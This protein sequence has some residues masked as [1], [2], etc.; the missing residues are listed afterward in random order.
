MQNRSDFLNSIRLLV[1]R[2]EIEDSE[3]EKFLSLLTEARFET[4]QI[5][6]LSRLGTIVD[7]VKADIEREI[8][9][10]GDPDMINEMN[11][12]IEEIDKIEYD[13]SMK[14]FEDAGI[15]ESSNIQ[16]KS[17]Q[18]LLDKFAGLAE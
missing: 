18:W 12:M 4:I 5:E 16:P 14:A 3:K 17:G 10:S 2:A 1:Q 13:A 8:A 15:T 11:A 6:D 9:E 7:N